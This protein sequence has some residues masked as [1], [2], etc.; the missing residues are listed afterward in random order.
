MLLPM[1][2]SDDALESI[3]SKL[4]NKDN[5]RAPSDVVLAF[6]SL[7]GAVAEPVYCTSW[8]EPP[9][10]FWLVLAVDGEFL[11]YV[12]AKSPSPWREDDDRPPESLEAFVAPIRSYVSAVGIGETDVMGGDYGFGMRRR[13]IR[14]WH[15]S[16][17]LTKDRNAG[18][19]PDQIR[20][21]S[22]KDRYT[23]SQHDKADA[24]VDAI[25]RRLVGRS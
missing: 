17:V 16:W 23:E 20:L 1:Q 6:A 3:W 22:V 4:V 7:G 13:P 21:P 11:I 18:P 25:R 19:G 2:L 8:T 24:V 15:P 10:E 12:S 14:P 5:I 9:I